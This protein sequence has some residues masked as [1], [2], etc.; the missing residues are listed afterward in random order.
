[1]TEP[2]LDE[3]LKKYQNSFIQKTYS[4]ENNTS[5][6]L[7]DVFGLSSELKQENKQYWGRE[8]GMCWQ[9]LI[10]EICKTFCANF[11]PAF[12]IGK[13]EP[14]DLVVDKYAIDTKY[15]IG[16]GDSGLHKK[17]KAYGKM[18]RQEG[19]EPILLILR[20]D[21]LPAAIKACEVGT[22]T[23]YT[24]NDSFN[25]IKE[26]SNFDLKQFLI[27]RKGDFPVQR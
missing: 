18:L 21:N 5:D 12:K 8:L 16:S 7:M 15:R 2:S 26:I 1:M 11:Q 14:C 13:D 4:D 23:I 10:V 3:I 19:Y 24:G 25:F 9:L 27:E 22:W 6:I 17:Y 20:E